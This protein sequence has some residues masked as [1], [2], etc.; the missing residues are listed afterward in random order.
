MESGKNPRFPGKPETV[1]SGKL[2]AIPSGGLKEAGSDG[3]VESFLSAFRTPRPWISLGL[4]VALGAL[5]MMKVSF[6]PLRMPT[7]SFGFAYL[8]LGIHLFLLSFIIK[9]AS[10]FILLRPMKK[11]RFF[12][13]FA[14]LLIGHLADNAMGMRVGELVRGI[15]QVIMERMSLVP[16]FVTIVLYRVID[17]CAILLYFLLVSYFIEMPESLVRISAFGLLGSILILGALAALR[18]YEDTLPQAI[19]SI[20]G[21]LG[22]W[23]G[24]RAEEIFDGCR[25]LDSRLDVLAVFILTLL[26]KLAVSGYYWSIGKAFGLNLPLQSPFALMG[27][28][29]FQKFVPA[30]TME[31][32]ELVMNKHL[33]LVGAPKGILESYAVLSYV[34]MFIITTVLGLFLLTLAGFYKGEP[35]Q[36]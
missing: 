8:T 30:R 36:S 2:I 25:A 14:S 7:N 23:M 31:A 17:G 5:S 29:Y 19:S 21:R 20:F 27:L 9:A 11:V 34:D 35:E 18:R 26:T 13:P 22:P 32:Y 1:G 3:V 15:A 33:G 12:S 16:V 6:S 28:I 24:R 10:W 4:L